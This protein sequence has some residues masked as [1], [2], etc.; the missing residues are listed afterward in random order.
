MNFKL[1]HSSYQGFDAIE[2]ILVDGESVQPKL[3]VCIAI[4]MDNLHLLDNR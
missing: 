1:S 4:L 2:D 3:L